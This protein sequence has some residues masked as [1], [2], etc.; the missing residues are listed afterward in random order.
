MG[1]YQNNGAVTETVRAEME[2]PSHVTDMS[3]AS[4]D[5]LNELDETATTS[6][7]ELLGVIAEL[8][9]RVMRLERAMVML[10]AEN[11]A[12]DPV[13]SAQLANMDSPPR[14][15]PDAAR[16]PE[17]ARPAPAR[18][19]PPPVG[20]GAGR[21]RRGLGNLVPGPGPGRDRHLRQPGTQHLGG[22]CPCGDR[23]RTPRCQ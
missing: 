17:P 20:P 10:L 19:A 6:V 13:E 7:E 9:E 8:S 16:V 5:D 15:Q 12:N 14:T 21:P 23:R 2:R 1:D 11:H 3:D 18:P 22:P 4:S